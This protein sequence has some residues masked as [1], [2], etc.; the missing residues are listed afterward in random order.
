MRMRRV[1]VR[2]GARVFISS[3]LVLVALLRMPDSISEHGR[4]QLQCLPCRIWAECQQVCLSGNQNST[5]IATF[6]GLSLNTVTPLFAAM[7]ANRIRSRR[8]PGVQSAERRLE[9]HEAVCGSKETRKPNR[10]VNSMN[11]WAFRA[12]VL[13]LQVCS[14]L[15]ERSLAKTARPSVS[16]STDVRHA[17]GIQSASMASNASPVEIARLRTWSGLAVKKLSKGRRSQTQPCWLRYS[18]R[19]NTCS[20]LQAWSSQLTQQCLST[21]PANS[22]SFSNRQLLTLY[23]HS[24]WEATTSTSLQSDGWPPIRRLAV[25]HSRLHRESLSRVVALPSV[26]IP[27]ATC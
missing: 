14:V 5:A 20:Q 11:Y 25:G 3:L 8:M 13:S 9:Q 22:V 18:V 26:A 23:R 2:S 12:L 15:L 10:C 1:S 17:A 6:P 21:A 24:G 19:Q 4:A 16:V 7:R 27:M